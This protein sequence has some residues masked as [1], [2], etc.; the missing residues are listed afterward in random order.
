M[1]NYHCLDNFQ[2]YLQ[3]EDYEF[4]CKYVY[5]IKHDIP[6]KGKM[7]LLSGPSRTG[8][9]TLVSNITNYLGNEL[10]GNYLMNGCRDI[11]SQEEIKKLIIFNDINEL[12]NRYDIRAIINLV[13]Y[14]Q[15]IIAVTNNYEN[16]NSEI[17]NYC[18][19]IKMTHIFPQ[20]A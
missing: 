4:V 10:Y 13:K 9:S 15:S 2:P 8:K 17:L 12:N 16:I 1:L 3:P 5:N 19:V 7:L 18:K 20:S 14:N 6:N 11:I